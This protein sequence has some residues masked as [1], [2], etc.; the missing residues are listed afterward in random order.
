MTYRSFSGE[1]KT[2]AF[3]DYETKRQHSIGIQV[4]D[5]ALSSSQTLKIVVIDVNDQ[6]IVTNLPYTKVISAQ[7]TMQNDIV[8]V[9]HNYVI[10]SMFGR[11]TISIH[12]IFW[13]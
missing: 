5:G 3:L 12:Y 13:S 11:E 10:T 6:H 2:A 9:C 1:I 4:S 7:K 8:S